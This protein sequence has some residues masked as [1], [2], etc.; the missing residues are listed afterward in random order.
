MILENG[1]GN[2]V[3]V[4]AGQMKF[5]FRFNQCPVRHFHAGRIAVCAAH[6]DESMAGQFFR[7]TRIVGAQSDMAMHIEHHGKFAGMR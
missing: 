5:R 1:H 7:R 3:R 6:H 4:V 2:R